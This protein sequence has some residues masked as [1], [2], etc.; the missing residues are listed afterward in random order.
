MPRAQ[1]DRE[2]SI[3]DSG[4]MFSVGMIANFR[5]KKKKRTKHLLCGFNA[6]RQPLMSQEDY[7]YDRDAGKE[8]N[9]LLVFI[10]FPLACFFFFFAVIIVL[11]LLFPF[12][13]VLLFLFVFFTNTATC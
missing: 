10:R 3:F 2:R 8:K 11:V 5:K 12:F 4:S 7:I 13:L 9:V 1:F 6:L